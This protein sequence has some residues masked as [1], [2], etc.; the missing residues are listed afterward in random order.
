MMKWTREGVVTSA[1][2]TLMLFALVTLPARADVTNGGFETGD[3]TG[4]VQTGDTGFSGVD[5]L[6]A[7]SGSFGAF[8]GPTAPGGI[9]QSFAT[10]ATMTYRVDFSLSLADSSQPNSF[11][12]AWNGVSQTPSLSNAA[13]FAF[14]SFS[15]LVLATGASSTLAF[16]FSNP[17]SF[18]LLDNISVVAVPEPPVTALLGVGV[19]FLAAMAKRR[20]KLQRPV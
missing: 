9:S 13:G 14:T 18:W 16:T 7:R 10:I 4:W 19:L 8:F 3:F 1:A 15:G 6:A 2:A 20:A 17:Q 12:W 5:P 11:S